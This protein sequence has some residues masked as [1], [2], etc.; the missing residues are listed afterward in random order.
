MGET[1]KLQNKDEQHRIIVFARAPRLGRV[2]TRLNKAIPL[3]QV[4]QLH[5]RLVRHTLTGAMQVSHACVELWVDENPSHLFF[6]DLLVEFPTLSL[7]LQ[8]PGDLGEKMSHALSQSGDEDLSSIIIGSDC[9]AIDKHY[10]EASIN[11]LKDQDLVIG[12]ASDGGYVLI[13]TKRS[14]LPVFKNIE[15]GTEQVLL[16]T[17]QLAVQAELQVR[18]MAELNDVDHPF[19][20]GE[21]HRFG[22]MD[23]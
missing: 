1:T 3:E 20:L 14:T 16:Q 13:G 12:P 17:L 15:W 19:D 21:A 8:I 7:K 5:E 10:I 4:L 18:L 2:K 23:D 11:A 9:P 22:L 6:R